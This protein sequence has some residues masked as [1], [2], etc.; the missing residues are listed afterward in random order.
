MRL[1]QLHTRVWTVAIAILLL[2]GFL[3]VGSVVAK[4]PKVDVCHVA[5]D[6][7]YIK[8]NISVNAL[9]KHIR[10]GDALIGA[11]VPGLLGF[12]FDEECNLTESC[13]VLG[14][15]WDAVR[16]GGE[17][18]CVCGA[19]T[20]AFDPTFGNECEEAGG[21]GSIASWGVGGK[22]VCIGGPP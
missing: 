11:E 18:T 2:F 22:C 15:N 1:C 17:D 13:S 3:S 10:H 20:I 14:E 7:G 6:Q 21:P 9:T 8:L 5:D 12:V 4:Q 19:T 16:S